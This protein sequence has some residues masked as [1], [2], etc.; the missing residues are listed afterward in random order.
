MFD[1]GASTRFKWQQKLFK[2]NSFSSDTDQRLKGQ[3]ATE[4]EYR[5]Y[6]QVRMQ[7]PANPH[8]SFSLKRLDLNL[9]ISPFVCFQH[10]A[11]YALTNVGRKDRQNE[12]I[13]SPLSV[14]Y[15]IFT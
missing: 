10:P 7:K 6:Q 8:Q 9:F 14:Q 15:F 2:S 4:I 12:E 3:A 5:T 1:L 13:I 11:L